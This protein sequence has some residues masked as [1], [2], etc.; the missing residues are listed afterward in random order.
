M[1]SRNK[2]IVGT[3]GSELALWQAEATES[4][5]RAAFPDMEVVRQVIKTTGDRRTDVALSQVAKSEGILDKGV[6]TKELEIALEAGEI[7]VAVHSLK[8]VPT[9]LNDHFMIPATLERAG[10]RDALVCRTEGGLAALPEGAK[11]GTSSVRRARQ[12]QWLRPDLL[13]CDL[14]GNVPTRLNKLAQGEEYDAI[15]KIIND[16][17]ELLSNEDLRYALIKEE[18]LEVKKRFGD[19]RKSH[20]EYQTEWSAPSAMP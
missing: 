3:R 12:L 16:L 10:V 6:F 9:V 11:V 1:E 4:L 5:L 20:I 14:R 7:D 13:L 18:L 15:M 8:D 2:I 19:E 17:K